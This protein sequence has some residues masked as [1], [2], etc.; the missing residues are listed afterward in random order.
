MLVLGIDPGLERIGYGAIRREGSRYQ[1]IDYGLIET[2][3]IALPDRLRL[4]HEQVASLLKRVQPDALATE[5]LVFAVNKKTAMDVSKALGV[6][7]LASSQQGLPWSE[8]TATQVKLSAVGMG[9]ARKEQVQYMI[10]QI[11]G[12]KE[13]PKPDDVA[14]ALA[15][16]LCHLSQSR[17]SDTL[18]QQGMH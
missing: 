6:V 11:L 7:L 1:V 18:V 13:I 8:Y 3:R 15:I 4:A 2:P 12:L 5:R 14:D 10:K 16:A 9:N 17:V